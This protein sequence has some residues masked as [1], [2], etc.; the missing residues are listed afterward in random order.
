MARRVPGFFMLA[1]LVAVIAILSI[2]R[3]VLM[4]VALAVL[5]AFLLSPGARF[6]ERVVSRGVA[7]SV[8]LVIAFGGLGAGGYLLSQQ[9]S[10]LAVELPKYRT[11]IRQRIADIHG[12]GRGGAIESLQSAVDP[13]LACYQRLLAADHGEASD[14]MERHIDPHRPAAMYDEVLVPALAYAKRERAWDRI[15]DDDRALVARGAREILASVAP[16]P[17]PPGPHAIPVVACPVQDELDELGFVMLHHLLDP[18]DWAIELASAEMLSSEVVA[19]VADKAPAVVCLGLVGHGSVAHAR[20]LVKRLR[21]AF[22]QSAIVVA[23]WGVAPF[24]AEEIDALQRAGATTVASTLS[25][26]RDRLRAAV[27]VE[28]RSRAAA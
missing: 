17:A 19:F 23:R 16:P 28:R 24:T 22:P 21:A 27:A 2:A 13:A 4:P 9:V 18:A 1:G 12:V 7:V 3:S 15:S 26:T 10:S 20:Y 5:L 6:L 11:N 8:M 25:E 14:I